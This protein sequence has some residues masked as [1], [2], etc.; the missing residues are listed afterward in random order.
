MSLVNDHFQNHKRYNI[1]PAQLII[2]DI[3]YNVGADAYGSNPQWYVDGQIENGQSAV[4]GKQF[5]DTD[6]DFRIPEFMHF[7]SRML[8]KEPKTT[9]DA[10]CMVVFCAFDQQ[11]QL[12]EEGRKHGFLN[13]INLVFRKNFSPQVLKANMRIVGNCEYAV[14]LYRDKLPKFRNHGRMIM[15]CMDWQ[16]DT[17]TPKVHPTQKP[18]GVIRRLVELFTDPGDVVIDPVA[19]SGV[20]LLAAESVGRRAYGFEIKKEFVRAFEEQIAPTLQAVLV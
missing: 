8:K 13:Y 3:P 17:I 1:P 14:V 16:R 15:N 20:T 4:A 18:V 7:T 10:G 9:G 19:G 11:M 12:I 5:F 6:S 2:A